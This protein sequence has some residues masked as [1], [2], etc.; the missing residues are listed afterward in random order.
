[1]VKTKLLATSAVAAVIAVSVPTLAAGAG[2]PVPSGPM[3]SVAGQRYFLDVGALRQR[4]TQKIDAAV[5][6]GWLT[7]RVAARLK[8]QLATAERQYGRNASLLRARALAWAAK[9]LGTTPAQLRQEIR[10]GMT[11]DQILAR[12]A[13]SPGTLLR[14]WLDRLDVQLGQ[15]LGMGRLS[16]QRVDA[17]LDRLGQRLGAAIERALAPQG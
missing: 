14:Q 11:L 16:R 2:S 15:S 6:A 4:L 10:A 13:G 8:Q 5:A 12:H 1:M 9:A 17:V 3:H 7:P